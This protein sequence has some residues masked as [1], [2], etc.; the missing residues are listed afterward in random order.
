M[1]KP[2]ATQAARALR[3]H[4]DADKARVLQRFFKTSPGEYGAGDVFIGVVVPATRRVGREFHD[5]ALGEIQKLL[6]SKVHEDRMLAVVI[7]VRQFERGDA[8]TQARIYA[9]YLKNARRINNWDLVDVS[10]AQIVGGFLWE[11]DRAVLKQLVRSQLL[12]ERRIAV[13]ATFYFIRRR[14]FSDCLDLCRALLN[15]EHDLM[16]K[17]CGWMLRE[18]GKRDANV[19]RGFLQTYSS[20][21][22]RTMLRYAI[23]KF[24]PAERQKWLKA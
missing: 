5:L 22:P 15:D 23:E 18:V 1:A 13:I 11:Q 9:F 7:L 4:A 8:A 20:R 16:H 2:T 14:D 6:H 10:A 17:A 24:T 12:W 19:L 3:R 21:M